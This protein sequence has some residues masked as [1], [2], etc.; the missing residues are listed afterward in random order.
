M[1]DDILVCH[2]THKFYTMDGDIP[3]TQMGEDGRL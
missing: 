3:G 1:A 2:D